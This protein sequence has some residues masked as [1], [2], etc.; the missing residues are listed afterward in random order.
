MDIE[1]GS[2]RGP[3]DLATAICSHCGEE[4]TAIEPEECFNGFRTLGDTHTHNTD[5]EAAACDAYHA[6]M[7]E[8]MAVGVDHGAAQKLAH[9]AAAA[10]HDAGARE[11][12]PTRVEEPD[13][14][15]E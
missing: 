11:A 6:T 4:H 13:G 15:Q 5:E 7:R 14:R 1:T 3:T 10:A 8:Q 2:G 12:Q 9:E